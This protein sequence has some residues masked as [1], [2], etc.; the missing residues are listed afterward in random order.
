MEHVLTILAVRDLQR[1]VRFYA[2][3]FGWP[4]IEEAPVYREFQLPGG[5][6][7]GLYESE[8]YARVTGRTPPIS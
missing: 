1:S 7:L 4:L 3:A 8:S 2:Q 6:R 5:R